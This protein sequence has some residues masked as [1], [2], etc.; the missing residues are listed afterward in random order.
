MSPA[1]EELRCIGR[2]RSEVMESISI[3]R[4]EHTD[5]SRREVI[6]SI[7]WM[8]FA[9]EDEIRIEEQERKA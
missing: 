2:I 7:A 4:S 1:E 8:L 5:S 6:Q 3:L 9:L